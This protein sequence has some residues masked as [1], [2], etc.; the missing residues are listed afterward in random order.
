MWAA[1]RVMALIGYNIRVSLGAAKYVCGL[2]GIKRNWKTVAE[3]MVDTRKVVDACP[4]LKTRDATAQTVATKSI[5]DM[6]DHLRVACGHTRSELG[7]AGSL[8]MEIK[9][10]VPEKDA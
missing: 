7:N 10:W 9:D 2:A 6:L 3:L 8:R 1:C 5:D 4:D